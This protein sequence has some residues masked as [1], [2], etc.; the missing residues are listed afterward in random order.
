MFVKQLYTLSRRLSAINRIPCGTAI[1]CVASARA[2][3]FILGE[4]LLGGV[5]ITELGTVLFFLVDMRLGLG[6]ILGWVH[7]G[8]TE[9]IANWLG[10]LVCI[11]ILYII[12]KL[13]CCSWIDMSSF[14]KSYIYNY[15]Y[16]YPMDMNTSLRSTLGYDSGGSSTFSDSGHGSIGIYI[17][18]PYVADMKGFRAA[19]PP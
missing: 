7:F 11:Q 19:Q 9:N 1:C 2:S 14:Q 4:G 3:L 16:I 15:I 5:K 18:R 10:K 12:Q 6:F 17:N 13:L 8:V